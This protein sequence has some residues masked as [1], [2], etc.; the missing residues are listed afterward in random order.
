M[1]N[2]RSSF[3]VRKSRFQIELCNC[4][5]GVDISKKNVTFPK[6]NKLFAGDFHAN[7]DETNADMV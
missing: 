6:R 4:R 5:D 7:L 3:A 1:Y 2:Q